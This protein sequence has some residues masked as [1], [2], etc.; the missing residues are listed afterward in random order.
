MRS[1]RK[2]T[3]VSREEAVGR[4]RS[5]NTTVVVFALCALAALPVP[6]HALKFK[7]LV[8]FDGTNGGLPSWA[9]VQGT[10]GKFYGSTG[11][12]GS[13][14]LG[15]IFKITPSGNLTT[16]QGITYSHLSVQGID[17][18]FYGTTP[19]D[20]AKQSGTVFRM[21]PKGQLTTLYEFCSQANCVDGADPYGGVIQASDGNLYGTTTGGGT[22]NY[23]TVFKITAGGKLTTLAS[24]DSPGLADTGVIEGADGSFYGTTSDG[25]TDGDGTIFKV[26]RRGVLTTLYSF[27]F[28]DGKFP[29]DALIQAAD[30]NFYGTT[31][32]GGANDAPDCE[33]IGC[34]TIF[35]IT[36][37]GTL[38][39][40]YNFCS[41]TNCAD[42]QWPSGGLVQG[43][44]GNF[45]GTTE[46][47]GAYGQ[48]CPFGVCGTVFKM[49][50]DGTLATLHS[51][52]TTD[53]S[54]PYSGLIQG[55][56]GTFYG[57]TN[58]GGDLSC[59]PDSGCGTIFRLSVGLAPFVETRPISG[60]IGA[61]IIILGNKLTGATAVS[62]NGT[63]ASFKVV[64]GTMI[65]AT[66]PS[67]ATSGTVEVVS[68]GGTLDSNVAFT[69]R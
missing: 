33:G 47:G 15:T 66:V 60:K 52:D 43:T 56:D 55:T 65:T 12:G 57:T 23:G 58:M 37:A 27:A 34:G 54:E 48:T 25:G 35:K 4:P 67:G 19:S 11:Y 10:N 5:Y 1:F 6:A 61:R 14:N 22:S 2:S 69:V 20:G 38:T 31:Y 7:T 50:P 24:F 9:P 3:F 32:I 44:D 21:T 29:Y 40:L 63:A 36:P 41:L 51:F 17:R 64:S 59:A 30:G 53:G 8:T 39:T 45:Y 46:A 28:T 62:F 13:G 68:P 49:T 16:L 42:G 18:E 26:T